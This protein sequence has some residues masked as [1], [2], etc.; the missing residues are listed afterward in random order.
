[1]KFGATG[2]GMGMSGMGGGFQ[3]QR[4]QKK[5]FFRHFCRHMKRIVLNAKFIEDQMAPNATK[6]VTK[7]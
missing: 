5:F 6:D 3:M 1:M 4:D 2:Y 7:V